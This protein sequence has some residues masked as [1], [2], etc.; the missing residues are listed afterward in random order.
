MTTGELIQLLAQYP[1]DLR[2]MADG[3]EGGVDDLEAQFLLTGDV[4]LN[5]N[6]KWYYGRHEE[7]YPGD[8]ETEHE[9]V[10]ALIFRRPW[11]DDAEM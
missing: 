4:R 1:D 5:V 2:V 10:P 6:T 8:K 3:Y 11:R 7:S 9:I